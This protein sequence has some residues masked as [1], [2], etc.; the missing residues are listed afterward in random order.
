MAPTANGWPA[1]ALPD[2]PAVP[3]F[4]CPFARA[5]ADSLCRSPS[6]LSAGPSAIGRPTYNPVRPVVDPRYLAW[7][8]TD[9]APQRV[10]ITRIR[11]AASASPISSVSRLCVPAVFVDTESIGSLS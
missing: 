9:H 11:Y 2:A 7:S 5:R 10:L 6:A 3:D 8:D 4:R 1:N